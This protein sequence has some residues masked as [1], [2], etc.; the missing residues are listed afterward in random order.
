MDGK[1]Y[2]NRVARLL[3]LGL[4]MKTKNAFLIGR[5]WRFSFCDAQ[6]GNSIK[7]VV[8]FVDFITKQMERLLTEL[9]LIYCL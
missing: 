2:E 6:K 4:Q 3:S 5:K 9:H 1:K 7:N 8:I